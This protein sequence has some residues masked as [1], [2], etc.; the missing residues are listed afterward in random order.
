MFFR[1][2]LAVFSCF[3]NCA[4]HALPNKGTDFEMID[5]LQ[6]CYIEEPILHP[7]YERPEFEGAPFK[8]AFG[9]RFGDWYAFAIGDEATGSRLFLRGRG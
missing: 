5:R 3:E 4:E 9:G 6:S 2:L 7:I 8:D 1:L